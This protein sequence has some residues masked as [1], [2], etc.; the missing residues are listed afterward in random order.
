ME[1]IKPDEG[2][3]LGAK[4]MSEHLNLF[5]DLSDHAKHTEI[6]VEKEEDKEGKS[7]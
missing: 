2:I 5:I 3:S 1:A 4:I 6:M 7:A